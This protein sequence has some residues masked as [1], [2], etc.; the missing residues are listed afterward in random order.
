MSNIKTSKGKITFNKTEYVL[1]N[2]PNDSGESVSYALVSDS[3]VHIG[4]DKGIIFFDLSC[5]INKETFT[6][7]NLFTAALY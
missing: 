3:Q 5:T 7:I 2:F 6:D 1:Q 4:T